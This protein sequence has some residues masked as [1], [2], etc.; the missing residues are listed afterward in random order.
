M[1]SLGLQIGTQEWIL[2]LL[3]ALVVWLLL[4]RG[5]RPS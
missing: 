5:G 4:R 3:V 2:I 1:R